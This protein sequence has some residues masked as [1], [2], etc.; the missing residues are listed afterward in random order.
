MG[1]SNKK[2]SEKV[3]YREEQRFGWGNFLVLLGLEFMFL[4]ESD[5]DFKIQHMVILAIIVAFLIRK[6]VFEVRE[7][8]LFMRTFLSFKQIHHTGLINCEKQGHLR[9]TASGFINPFSI[10]K[11][12]ISYY[13]DFQGLGSNVVLEF[14]DG[15]KIRFA[16]KNPEQLVEAIK[17][18]SNLKST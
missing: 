11:K 7:T 5:F 16:S 1:I 15:R 13:L 9:E 18:I 12:E 3:I 10:N 4:L 2:K 14:D 8:G 17:S 6:I